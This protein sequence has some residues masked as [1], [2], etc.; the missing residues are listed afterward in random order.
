V[1]IVD[2]LERR[3]S[4]VDAAAAGL[5]SALKRVHLARQSVRIAATSGALVEA[6]S[7]DSL[8]K[9]LDEK[10]IPYERV[11]GRPGWIITRL[12]K[13]A[14]VG[15]GST[16]KRGDK[17]Y[18]E[19]G[20]IPWVTSGQVNQEMIHVPAALITQAALDETSVKIWPA[21]T[22][23]LAM[24]GEGKTRGKC[25]ELAINSTCNQAC[26]AIYL[27]NDLSDLQPFIKLSLQS[28]YEENRG[29]GGGGV[30][31]N[32]NLG[33]VKEMPLVLPDF[34]VQAKL[35]A[36]AERR[37]SLIDVAE[38]TI[39]ANITKTEQLRRSVL[40]A[41]FDGQLVSQDPNDEP[42]ERLIE[43]IRERRAKQTTAKT[44]DEATTRSSTKTRKKEPSK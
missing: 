12:G 25:A 29:L 2:E 5:R 8:S 6:L 24:Y 36:E 15:S 28:R 27:E 21:G 37:L 10:G 30:Q 7:S 16:P 34:E 11:T 32:L 22:L 44:D 42:A 39:V 3:L 35:V 13:V 14:R 31:E 1:R 43:S 18:W 20:T 17:R 4:H 38:W 26:A 23:L 9:L 40:A 41:A 19:N 33:L